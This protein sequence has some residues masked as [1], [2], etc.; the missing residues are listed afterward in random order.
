VTSFFRDPE[1]FDT[2]DQDVIPRLFENRPVDQPIRVWVPG[3]STGEEAYSLAM[4]LRHH[5]DK[6]KQGHKVQIFATDIDSQAIEKAREGFYPNSIAADI[7]PERLARFFN[8][9]NSSFQVKNDIRDMVV[10]AVQSIIKDPPFSKLDLISCRN[11]LIYLG[12]QLQKKVVPLFH[13]ALNQGG[14]LFLGSSE[15]LGELDHLFVAIDRKWKL[16]QRSPTKPTLRTVLNFPAQPTLESE[17]ES[18]SIKP[19]KMLN[20]RELTEKMLLENYAP[21]SVIINERCEILYFYGRTGKYL[22]PASGEASLNLLRM[23]REGLRIPLTTAI[24]KVI[25]QKQAIAQENI[26]VETNGVAQLITLRVRPVQW[27]AAMQGLILVI[28]ENATPA[29]PLEA[30]DTPTEAGDGRQAGIAELELELKSTKEYLQTTIEELETS[31]EE[32]QSSNEELQSSNEELQSTNE[33]LETSK[34]ELQSVNEELVTV[35]SELQNKIDEL[36]RANNDM[37]N[38]LTN[39]DVGAIFLDL[40]LHIQRFNPA[41][42]R[43]INLISA[44]IG[45]P[46]GHIVSKLVDEDLTTYCQKVIDTL[47][48]TEKEV[49]TQ[50][51]KWYW[52]RVAP[53]RTVEHSVDGVVITF[54]EITVQKKVEKQLRAS[55]RRLAL[56]IEATGAGIY[57]HA[58]PLGPDMYHN[59]R[60]AEI[61][62]YLPDELPAPDQLLDWLYERVHPDDRAGLEQAYTDLIE[63]RAPVYD[64]E[65]RLKDNTGKWKWVRGLAK[66]VQRDEEGQITRVVGVMLNMV[67]KQKRN[68]A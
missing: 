51:G 21:A 16:F 30:S 53:Y 39:I 44:D 6:L 23:A 29:Q 27:P 34:E 14:Y 1:A 11:L 49:Q 15:T 33:E 46:V 12:P 59:D 43:I 62:G 38:L 55:E 41:A 18:S 22:E 37:Q 36:I 19:D 10:F 67:H 50:D 60:W 24:R 35:N 58:V 3:C 5:Q 20:L 2:L 57:E 40:K 63:G 28:F 42:T 64:V 17:L 45:R 13:Y 52:M 47:E 61:L 68:K 54:N 32:L 65:L 66:A 48:T 26:R 9:E 8:Q 25:T 31:N 56:A 4:L 7:S